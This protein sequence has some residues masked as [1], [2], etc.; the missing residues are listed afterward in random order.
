MEGAVTTLRGVDTGFG[1]G[2]RPEPV[3]FGGGAKLEGS[4]REE[5]GWATWL[6]SS[7]PLDLFRPSK[8]DYTA[9]P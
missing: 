5:S 7:L 4:R 1:A 8:P 9:E 2:A 3:R 6:D